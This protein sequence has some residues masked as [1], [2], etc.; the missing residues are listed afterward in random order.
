MF[1][2][3]NRTIK[4]FTLI[5]L[6]VVIAIIAMLASIIIASLNSARAK[7]RDSVRLADLRQVQ[8]ALELYATNNGGRYPSTGGAWRAGSSAC[9]A[10]YGSGDPGYGATGYISGLVPA[11]ISELP[12]DP[13]GVS[14]NRCYLYFSNGTDYQFLA[15]FTVETAPTLVGNPRPRLVTDGLSST[16]GDSNGYQPTFALY[17]PGGQCW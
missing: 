12:E 10:T 9:N 13:K 8:T 2:M 7:A 14:A 6:L 3:N 11:Y 16:C 5:E 4:G 1:T 17:S 15:W